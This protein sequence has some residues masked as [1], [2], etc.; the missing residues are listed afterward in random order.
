MLALSLITAQSKPISPA[1]ES[2]HTPSAHRLRG[3]S[4]AR[5]GFQ[6]IS[7]LQ[8][9]KETT[10]VG[11]A[12]QRS[13]RWRPRVGPNAGAC[14][15]LHERHDSLQPGRGRLVFRRQPLAVP[16]PRGT[17]G[18]QTGRVPASAG[19]RSRPPAPSGPSPGREE[20]HEHQPRALGQATLEIG[21]AELHH[22]RSASAEGEQQE[23]QQ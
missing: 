14:A 20:L 4:P 21:I 17:E 11:P 1:G 8:G 23:Q 3:C 12:E 7:G 16:A 9:I 19:P 10:P 18:S 13:G 6:I 5:I 2:A 22:V 15:H